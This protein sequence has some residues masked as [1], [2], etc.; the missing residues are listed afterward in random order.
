MSFYF[1]IDLLFQCKVMAGD[2]RCISSLDMDRIL[3]ARHMSLWYQY[4]R[5]SVPNLLDLWSVCWRV[6]VN[7]ICLKIQ[8]AFWHY[9]CMFEYSF[10]LHLGIGLT[11]VR[12]GVLF[13]LSPLV[14]LFVLSQ[15]TCL[16]WFGSIFCVCI[17][18]FAFN[19]FLFGLS[20]V[21]ISLFFPRC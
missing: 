17:F 7:L 8:M 4:S 5:N 3:G 11:V 21:G 16:T 20:A 2:D 6:R 14:F 9:W 13:R 19:C 1:E 15:N 18:C 10:L 12:P